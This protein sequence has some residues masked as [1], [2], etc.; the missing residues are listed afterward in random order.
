MVLA[1]LFA[2][3]YRGLK[4][5]LRCDELTKNDFFFAGFLDSLKNIRSLLDT[6]Y[7]AILLDFEVQ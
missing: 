1:I 7:S 6:L 3:Y 5:L 2:E 4:S